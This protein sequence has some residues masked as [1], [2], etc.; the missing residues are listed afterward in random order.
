[1]IHDTE[2]QMLARYAETG[3]GEAFRRLVDLHQAMVYHTCRRILGNPADAEDAAQNCFYQLVRN[4]R[5]V[6]PPVGPWLHRVAVRV[7]LA[8]VHG[9]RARHAREICA[10]AAPPTPDAETWER[11][12]ADVDECIAGMP[13]RLRT[14]VVLHYLEGRTQ[15]D[16]AAQLRVSQSTVSRRLEG[17]LDALRKKLVRAGILAPGAALAA[18]LASNG[19]EAAPPTLGVALGKVGFAGA[20]AGT[21]GATGTLGGMTAAKVAG[22]SAVAASVLIT[23]GFLVYRAVSANKSAPQ[24]APVIAAVPAARVA[25]VGVATEGSPASDVGPAEES[26]V[27]AGAAEEKEIPAAAAVVVPAGGQR[28]VR[29]EIRKV[30]VGGSLEATQRFTRACR[31]LPAIGLDAAVAGAAAGAGVESLNTVASAVAFVKEGEPGVLTLEEEGGTVLRTATVRVGKLQNFAR[32]K[33]GVKT[34]VKARRVPYD[35]SV[36]LRAGDRF[37]EFRAHSDWV[38][39]EGKPIVMSTGGANGEQVISEG[40]TV[41]L[42]DGHA[43]LLEVTTA[44]PGSAN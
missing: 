18:L 13:D 14:V 8:M 2:G 35:E 10:V 26:L 41:P 5:S 3:D 44:E 22:I 24:P 32:T 28:I 33:D 1:M 21:K 15:E 11:I 25:P 39:P 42:I 40:V 27:P 16:I 30:V 6:R 38:C 36:R 23:G 34:L 43:L 4:V 20:A 31:N 9:E 19:V 7:S 12:K 17:G 37:N 29:V